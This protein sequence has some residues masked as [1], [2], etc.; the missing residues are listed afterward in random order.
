MD[1]LNDLDAMRT[2]GFTAC[3]ADSCSEVKNIADYVSP[4]KGGQGVVRD[5]ARYLL[6]KSGDWD[7][8]IGKLYCSGI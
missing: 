6:E 8:I 7:R 2:A 4:V 3:P 1:D 5:V